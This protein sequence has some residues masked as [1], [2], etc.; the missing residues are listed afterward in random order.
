MRIAFLVIGN[1]RRSN[2]LDGNSIKTGGGG[3]SGTDTSNILVAEYLANHGHE[4]VLCTDRLEPQIEKQFLEKGISPPAGKIVNRVAYTDLNFSG[5]ENKVFDILVN[6]LWFENYEDLPIKV[7]K[8]LIYWSHMQWLYGIGNIKKF[9]TDNK[10]KLGV[11][12]ISHWEKQMNLGAIQSFTQEIPNFLTEII[13]NPVTDDIIKKVKEL[14]IP[15]KPG[16][17]VFHAAW[18]RGGEIAYKLI[19]NLEIKD[20]E[21]HAF[22]YLMVAPNYNDP[23]LISHAGVDKFTVF[24]HLAECEYYLYPLYTPYQDVHK[25]TFGCVI[26]EAIAL[27]VTPITYPLGALP[28]YFSDFCKWVDVPQP[29]NVLEMQ[30]EPLTKDYQGIFNTDDYLRKGLNSLYTEPSLKSYVQEK[31]YDYILSNFSIDI[32]GQKWVEFINKL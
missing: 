26:A 2:Y 5:I 23:M 30:N 24:K 22:D 21:L 14:N 29:F 4:V 1:G 31:G 6:N 7:T 13:P 25:D 11:I 28:E 15:K 18:A 17:F 8:G 3:A 16:K 32:I 27:G 19:K 9:V 10:L 12:S 20:K